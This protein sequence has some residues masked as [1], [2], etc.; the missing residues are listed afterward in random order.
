MRLIGLDPNARHLNELMGR[1]GT[2]DLMI[3]G[4]FW[5]RRIRAQAISSLGTFKVNEL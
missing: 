2:I 5:P 4:V 1:F 3:I